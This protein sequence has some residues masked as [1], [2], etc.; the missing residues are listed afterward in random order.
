MLKKNTR[1]K[2][3]YCSLIHF[4]T[5]RILLFLLFLL[6]VQM[7]AQG[8][9]NYTAAS[10]TV[11]MFI[12]S[13]QYTHREASN[14]TFYKEVKTGNYVSK[15][16]TTIPPV[17]ADTLKY[18]TRL[19]TDGIISLITY[20][21]IPT[22]DSSYGAIRK[23]AGVSY[24]NGNT[25]MYMIEPYFGHFAC[26][27]LLAR[28][29]GTKGD[30]D[31]N[32]KA[33][34]YY[35][36]WYI[37]KVKLY[38]PADFVNDGN[39]DYAEPLM[40]NYYYDINGGNET[41]C[42]NGP[43]TATCQQIDA[44]DSEITLFV[45]LAY[46]YFKKT[47]D[48]TWFCR[49][50]VRKKME[51]YIRLVYEKLY[52]T[53]P[54]WLTNAKRSY[55]IMYM[56]DNSEVYAGMQAFLGIEKDIYG[57]ISC[58]TAT[59]E[60]T[61]IALSG[62]QEM[63]VIRDAIIRHKMYPDPSSPLSGLTYM[64]FK[65][66]ANPDDCCDGYMDAS[67]MYAFTP[68]TW[69]SIFG[70]DPGF[71]SGPATF[72]RNLISESMPDWYKDDWYL[73]AASTGFWGTSVGYFFYLSANTTDREHAEI[74]AKSASSISFKPYSTDGPSLSS[75]AAW[76]LLTLEMISKGVDPTTSAVDPYVLYKY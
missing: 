8:D 27:A 19:S 50:D 48:Y 72:A 6:P 10:D 61:N 74:S 59:N 58:P 25:A 36:D 21:E 14:G 69:P 22:T 29:D 47:G 16:T 28:V 43:G 60:H 35:M 44:E 55:P 3:F 24:Y 66:N 31:K 38:N 20:E 30:D 32:I 18:A 17:K 45:M 1:L 37:N 15:S 67:T 51:G 2:D 26:I 75:D 53:D 73:S 63:L 40:V 41:D 23:G 5:N 70:I 49:D 9:Y 54:Y 39:P 12:R 33:V 46:H 71:N 64:S 56:M 34:R 4:P 13:L 65:L 62:A 11:A 52:H 68:L 42:P 76:L 7:Q 57:N